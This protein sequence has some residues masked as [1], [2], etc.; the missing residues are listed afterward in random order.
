M[1]ISSGVH[2]LLHQSSNHQIFGQINLKGYYLT[3]FKRLVWDYKKADVDA[4][5][6][7]I[8]SFNRGN[9]FNGKVINSQV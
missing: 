2:P 6:L 5:N 7:A 9:D 4:L 1:V 8:K 3:P